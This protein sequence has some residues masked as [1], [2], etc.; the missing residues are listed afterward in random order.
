MKDNDLR[1]I[2]YYH[3][4]QASAIQGN[5]PIVAVH[6]KRHTLWACLIEDAHDRIERLEAAKSAASAMLAEILERGVC[7]TPGCTC[8]GDRKERIKSVIGGLEGIK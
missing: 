8:D 7:I 1:K 3:K 6:Q 4:V 5:S 2:A